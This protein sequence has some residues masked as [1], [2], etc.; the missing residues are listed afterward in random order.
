[1]RR[2]VLNFTKRTLNIA[3]QILQKLQCIITEASSLVQ[4][5]SQD[6][7]VHNNGI[8]LATFSSSFLAQ[9]ITE[10]GIL[11]VLSFALYESKFP[12]QSDNDN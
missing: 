1:V 9:T 7:L 12:K 10:I 8:N 11:L 4:F 2:H 5:Q 6:N 3:F